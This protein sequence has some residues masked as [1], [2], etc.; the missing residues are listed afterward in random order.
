M[1]TKRTPLPGEIWDADFGPAA[2]LR[3]VVVL[4]SPQQDDA[5]ALYIVVSLTTQIRNL[6]GEVYLGMFPG[7]RQAS[8]VNVQ[9]LSS[10]DVS[11]FTNRRGALRPAQM[12]A[13]KSALRDLLDL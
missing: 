4:Y 5:R 2:K 1:N 3:P 6:R 12:D 7:L 8:A 9:A 10:L 11:R 13:V